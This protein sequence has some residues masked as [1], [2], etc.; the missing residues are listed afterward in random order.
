MNRSIH[1]VVAVRA[2]PAIVVVLALLGVLAITAC[3]PRGQESGALDVTIVSV[4]PDPATVGDAVLTLEIRDADGNPIE[5]ATIEVEGV[6]THAGM[7]PVIVATEALGEGKY[8]TQDF[9]FTM[10]GDWVIIVHATLADGATVQQ[11]VDV[12]GVQGEMNM[13][14]NSKDSSREGN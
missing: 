11:R 5:G 2:R 9:K 4:S 10:G 8:A 12:K 7:Q 1:D 13:D 14:M 3:G 6:M